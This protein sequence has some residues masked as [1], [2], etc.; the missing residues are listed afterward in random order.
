L[1]IFLTIFTVS[2]KLRFHCFVPGFF[3]L[4]VLIKLDGHFFNVMT[5]D[6][7]KTI[8]QYDERSWHILKGKV[9]NSYQ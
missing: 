7:H 9:I 5:G 8:E 2:I 1:I 6:G 3:Y 4:M